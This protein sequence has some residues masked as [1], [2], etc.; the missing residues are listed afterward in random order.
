MSRFEHTW[1]VA[2]LGAT[3]AGRGVERC[4]PLEGITAE[5]GKFYATRCGRFEVQVLRDIGGLVLGEVF[6]VRPLNPRDVLVGPRYPGKVV[7]AF[8]LYYWAKDGR[9]SEDGPH[10]MDLVAELPL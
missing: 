7:R 9:F 4:L 3:C 2:T 1:P 6:A 8:E 5:T 10:A